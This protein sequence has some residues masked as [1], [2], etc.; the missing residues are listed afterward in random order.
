VTWKVDFKQIKAAIPIERAARLLN[1][2]LKT[3]QSGQL[4]GHCPTCQSSDDT[5][6][7]IT[8]SKQVFFCHHGQTGGDCIAL[9][10]HILG[11][12]QRDAAE[13]LHETL[14]PA[15][16]SSRTTKSEQVAASSVQHSPKVDKS[17][18]FDPQ[19]Y[20][21]KL[22]Y[23]DEIRALGISEED[24]RAVGLGSV[25][26]GFNKG[27]TIA[28]RWE[29]GETACYASVVEGKL[30]VPPRSKWIEPKV[31]KLRRA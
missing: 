12:S 18:E 22:T 30:K 19:K 21:D 7:A 23:T 25:S 3:R 20:L 6:L 5:A 26:S 27:L 14:S 4:R 2:E 8:P 13:W 10:A 29:T 31:V 11:L 28:I 1:L 24:A 17:R 16:T 15:E 9:V